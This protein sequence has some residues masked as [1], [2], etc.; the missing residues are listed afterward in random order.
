MNTQLTPSQLKEIQF[1]NGTVPDSMI[2][3]EKSDL[4]DQYIEVANRMPTHEL[5]AAL[6]ESS[7]FN[8][9][10]IDDSEDDTFRYVNA[11]I[12]IN[13]KYNHV[14][15]NNLSQYLNDWLCTESLD[16]IEREYNSL[17]VK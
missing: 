6:N 8:G 9:N 7:L 3:Q 16:V 14:I 17:L 15:N 11:D 13:G 2:S 4:I 10:S 12:L 5:V 1:A